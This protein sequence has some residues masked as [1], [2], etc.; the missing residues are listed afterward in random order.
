MKFETEIR[1]L[2]KKINERNDKFKSEYD[3]ECCNVY[4]V[5]YPVMEKIEKENESFLKGYE[6]ICK[7]HNKKVSVP[8]GFKN[9][10]FVIF[11]EE[12]L[13]IRINKEF[14]VQSLLLSYEE[15]LEYMKLIS[16]QYMKDYFDSKDEEIEEFGK[17]QIEKKL[18]ELR[19]LHGRLSREF[20]RVHIDSGMTYKASIQD[21]DFNLLA[22]IT[23][24]KKSGLL[25]PKDADIIEPDKRPRKQRKDRKKPVFVFYSL[26]I[27]E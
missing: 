5:D 21:K 14:A 17:R 18:D 8:R 24:P 16:V 7:R 1:K 26:S 15:I 23:I 19:F 2:Y 9:R 3:C 20:Y 12:K 11:K 6:D 13:T 4:K 22:K 10:L 27:V 25:V